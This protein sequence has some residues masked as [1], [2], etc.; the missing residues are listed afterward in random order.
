MLPLLSAFA[1]SADGGSA[2]DAGTNGG[3]VFWLAIA[4]LSAAALLLFDVV[5]RRATVK[6]ALPFF[7]REPPFNLVPEPPDEAAKVY[8]VA[9]PGLKND[10][11]EPLHLSV[12]VIPADGPPKGAALFCPETGGSK[13]FWKRYARALPPAGVAV[14]SFEHRG[15]YDSDADPHHAPGHWPTESEVTDANAVLRR[16]LDA[17][18]SFDLPAGLPVATFGISRGGCVALAVA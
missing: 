13:W 2:A 6:F 5:I 7:E 8:R 10:R 14:V 16:L 3:W 17:P 12:A 1:Q 9:V 11:D 18:E 4:A 15:M